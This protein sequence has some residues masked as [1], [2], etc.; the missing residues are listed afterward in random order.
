M[1]LFFVCLF[2]TSSGNLASVVMSV[3][4]HGSPVYFIND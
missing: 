4:K 2:V 1:S 3:T